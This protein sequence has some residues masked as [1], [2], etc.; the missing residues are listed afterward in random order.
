MAISSGTWKAH[1]FFISS[2]GIGL[3]LFASISTP[4][5]KSTM[6]RLEQFAAR[7][8][9]STFSFSSSHLSKKTTLLKAP[10]QSSR[11]RNLRLLNLIISPNLSHSSPHLPIFPID[12]TP[13]CVS[14][15]P[16]CL[17]LCISKP[18]HY[19]TSPALPRVHA[20]T[21]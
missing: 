20:C 12:Q 2:E 16:S 4:H 10:H 1:L 14:P 17:T 21:T 9:F 15:T 7:F 8:A 19:C 18:A 11:L 6:K 5:R 3:V 13:K